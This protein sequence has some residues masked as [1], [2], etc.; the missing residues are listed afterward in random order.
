MAISRMA[1]ARSG[2][3]PRGAT[4]RVRLIPFQV[5]WTRKPRSGVASSPMLLSPSAI[6]AS[7]REMVATR[8]CFEQ[9]AR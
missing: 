8:R 3:R 2:A 7:L 4:P 5:C 1:E 6:A 9:K